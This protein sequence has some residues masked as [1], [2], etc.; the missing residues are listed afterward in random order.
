M[1]L[2]LVTIS[3]K[4]QKLLIHHFREHFNSD[5]RPPLFPYANPLEYRVL[6]V[7]KGQSYSTHHLTLESLVNSVDVAW[8]N[9][10]EDFI[11]ITCFKFRGCLEATMTDSR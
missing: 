11:V 6:G 8:N 1:A 9:M 10:L 4:P 5:L 2:Y 7:L 3:D